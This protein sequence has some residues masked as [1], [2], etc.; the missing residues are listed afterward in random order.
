MDGDGAQQAPAGMDEYN[1]DD[2][3]ALA[4]EVAAPPGEGFSSGE[5]GYV[6]RVEMIILR[7]SCAAAL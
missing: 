4:L 7:P 6:T 5:H 1:L 2:S 3:F